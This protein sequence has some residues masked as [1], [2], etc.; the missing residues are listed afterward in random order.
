MLLDGDGHRGGVAGGGEAKE[1]GG[2]AGQRRGRESRRCR[3]RPR[4]PWRSAWP[5]ARPG[6]RPCAARRAAT[7]R[8][9]PDRARPCRRP[10]GCRPCREGGERSGSGCREAA[11]LWLVPET[12][13][14][15]GVLRARA[16]GG[17]GDALAGSVEAGVD[18]GCLALGERADGEG[19]R[20][21]AGW[22]VSAA[23]EPGAAMPLPSVCQATDWPRGGQ[24]VR[25]RQRL[26]GPGEGGAGGERKLRRERRRAQAAFRRQTA[27]EGWS[28]W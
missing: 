20:G 1:I 15:S 17:E 3:R 12:G 9:A 4:W 28:R 24:A 6:R 8:R 5:A 23:A 22:L 16:E 21:D 26:D 2:H 18:G 7:R 14:S 19:L 25:E 10:W 13:S 11:R 27:P